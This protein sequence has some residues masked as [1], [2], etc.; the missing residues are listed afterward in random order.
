MII[1]AM[2]LVCINHQKSS[3]TAARGAEAAEYYHRP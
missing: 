3:I 2:I 1:F